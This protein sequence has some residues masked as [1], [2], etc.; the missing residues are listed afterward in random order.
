MW[1]R[2]QNRH[3]ESTFDRRFFFAGGPEGGVGAEDVDAG[4]EQVVVDDGRG[5]MGTVAEAA[6]MTGGCEA[7]GAMLRL[8]GGADIAAGE[9]DGAASDP[10]RQEG[11]S[12]DPQASWTALLV[13]KDPLLLGP[14]HL[15]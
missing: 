15:T 6:G 12:H 11:Q 7:R 10:V 5:A 1:L 8:G 4:A 13:E 9:A 3:A 14:R 2:R